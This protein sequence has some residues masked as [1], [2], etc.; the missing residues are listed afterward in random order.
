MPDWL[1]EGDLTLYAVVACVGLVCLAVWW[2]TRRRRYAVI[3]GLA[4]VALVGLVLLDRYVESD[5]EQMVR[6]VQEIAVA[7]PARDFAHMFR[8]I[9]DSFNR[10]GFDKQRFRDFA[11]S[12]SRA[13]NVTE[14][15]PWDFVP[16]PVS[17][18]ARRGE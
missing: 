13:R 16:G 10:H 11:E 3:A 15:T 4:A 9:S 2:R 14:F 6:K 12:V 1:V 18:A 5:R 8:H 17:R 7:V